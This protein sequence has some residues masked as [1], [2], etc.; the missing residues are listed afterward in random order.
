MSPHDVSNVGRLSSTLRSQ[1]SDAES[2]LSAILLKWA[3]LDRL[4]RV[5]IVPAAR[6]VQ[7]RTDG[8]SEVAFTG[9]GLVDHLMTL[10][11]PRA[12]TYRSDREKF[13]RINR[14]VKDVLEDPDAELSVPYDSQD[15]HVSL[16]GADRPLPLANHGTG[17]AQ[18]VLIATLATLNDGQLLAIEEPETHVHPTMLRKLVRYL[19]DRTNNQYLIATHSAALLD[20]PTVGVVRVNYDAS[21]GTTTEAALTGHQRGRLSAHLGFRSSDLL[22]SNAILWVEGPSD[23]VY[24]NH[25]IWQR[26]PRFREGVHYS[27]MFY[28][29]KLLSRVTGGDIDTSDDL[30]SDFVSLI[31]INRNMA[32]LMDSDKGKPDEEIRATKSRLLAEL[33]A[34]GMPR[35]VTA[36]REIENYIP[37]DVFRAACEVVHPGVEP[38]TARG[39]F[40]K[41]F[42]G[43]PR[44]NKVRVAEEVVKTK[45]LAALLD[46]E[47]RMDVILALLYR[48]NDLR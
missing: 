24:L 47:T 3:Q 28:G 14:F 1:A 5:D 39:Q 42:A 31:R 2:D 40:S 6:S 44:P 26:E 9:E 48:V 21:D 15:V 27:I 13:A 34:V 12:E 32:I 18:V 35:W 29:G 43:I 23:R 36:G 19:R 38:A 20:D 25:W 4:P 8:G 41:R 17:I 37:L 45:D 16:G 7:R 22:Q 30:M 46:L 10:Q 33:S 11:A